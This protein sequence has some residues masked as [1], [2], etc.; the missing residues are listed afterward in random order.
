MGNRIDI[1]YRHSRAIVQEIGERLR[2]ILREEPELPASLRLQIDQLRELEHLLPER[3]NEKPLMAK[4]EDV[5]LGEKMEAVGQLTG[6]IAHD[7]NNLLTVILGNI[8]LLSRRLRGNDHLR[9]HLSATQYAA[10]RGQSVTRQL[11][12]FRDASTCNPRRST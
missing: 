5:R 2:A 11:P 12:A 6:G 3:P 1:D 8:D 10:E 9:R 4:C 7:F